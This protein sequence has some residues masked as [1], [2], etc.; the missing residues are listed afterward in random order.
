MDQ[1]QRS[2]IR[3]TIIGLGYVGTSIGLALKATALPVRVVGHDREPERVREAMRQ[4]AIDESHWNV[5]R[6]VEGADLVVVA[7]PLTEIAATFRHIAENLRPNAVVVDTTSVKVPVM[8]WAREHLPAHVH[9]VG[10]HPIVRDVRVGQAHA[11]ADLFRDEIFAL[12][13]APDVTAEAVKLVTD[14]VTAM[15]ARPLFLDAIEHDSMVAAVEHLPQLL[16][17][18]LRQTVMGESSWRD[19]RKLAGSQFEAT[20]YLSE[21]EPAAVVAQLM[22]NRERVLQWLD[23]LQ[24][25]L[26][27]LQA[28]LAVAQD[29]ERLTEVVQPVFKERAA[30]LTAAVTKNWDTTD[31][32]VPPISFTDWLFGQRW[33]SLRRQRKSS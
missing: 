20:T 32:S 31:A 21:E 17:L 13:P 29:Q 1:E 22:A 19:M 4:G 12:C 30:W 26:R 28:Q 16:A 2:Q 5:P 7:L 33:T 25:R 10:G 8:R 9:F 6:S 15:G 14:I 23:M 11:R 18:A 3:V 24:Q 27:W